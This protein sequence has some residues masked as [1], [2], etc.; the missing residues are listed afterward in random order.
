IDGR[1]TSSDAEGRFE[2]D[3]L[4]PGHWQLMAAQGVI[5]H[6]TSVELQRGQRFT[7]NPTLDPGR[8]LTLRLLDPAEKPMSG[9]PVE[10]TRPDAGFGQSCG[11]QLTDAE[12]RCRFEHLPPAE[13]RARFLSELHGVCIAE[14]TVTPGEGVVDVHVERECIPSARL[15]G[16]IV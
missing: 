10:L 9:Y 2:L 15:T 14:R 7:W 13:Y 6:E 8:D 5:K 11:A 16:R 4:A 12:G 1:C 3:G